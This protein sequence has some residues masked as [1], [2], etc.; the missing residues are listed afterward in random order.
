[1][2]AQHL[3]IHSITR[4]DAV[5]I[6]QQ[7]LDLGSSTIKCERLLFEFSKKMPIAKKQE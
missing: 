5:A 6:V 1:M 3:L 2:V 4:A 7:K